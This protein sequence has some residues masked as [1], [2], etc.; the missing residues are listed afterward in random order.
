MVII[1]IKIMRKR[2]KSVFA[3]KKMI[4]YQFNI[5]IIFKIIINK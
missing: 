4:V 3:F 1:M 5:I 2:K